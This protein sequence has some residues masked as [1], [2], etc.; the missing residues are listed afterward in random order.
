[1]VQE[2]AKHFGVN[3]VH[4]MLV[5]KYCYYSSTYA[6]P[7]GNL[8]RCFHT[9]NTEETPV[10]EGVTITRENYDVHREVAVDLGMCTVEQFKGIVCKC[11]AT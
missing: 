10:I 3:D 11:N 4:K 5:N 7:D 8:N 2:S 6:S 9:A 1:M